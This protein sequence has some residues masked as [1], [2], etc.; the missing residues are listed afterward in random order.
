VRALVT[1]ASGFT[2]SHLA[3]VLRGKGHSVRALA[4]RSSNL[5]ALR[6]LNL[7]VAWGDLAEDVPLDEALRGIDVVFHVAA[8]YRTEGVPR[9]AFWDVNVGGTRRLLE[10]ARRAGVRRF[11]HCSTVGVQGDI[12]H[13]P[14]RE[15]APYAPGDHYQESKRDGEILALEF[16]RRE[17]LPV[18]VVRPTGIYGPGDTRFLKLFKLANRGT[19]YMLG[20]GN[21]LYHLTYV[22]DLAEGMILASMVEKAV[23]EIFTLGG[24]EPLTLNELV[25]KVAAAMGRT[26]RVR[27]LPV[28]PFWLAGAACEALCRPLRIAPP[29]YRRRVDFFTK[30]RAFDIS[31]ARRILGYEPRVPLEEGLRRTSE[32][33]RERGLLR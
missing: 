14:A 28:A 10:A 3:R 12:K 32:W 4:R 18:T 2:G 15:D 19:F 7:E 30:T 1:G 13:P 9:Q 23:G 16:G 20:S 25:R 26:V 29:I 5:S 8:L 17:G 24:G 6:D 11:V 22:T 27:R 21:V 33:Y 31:K